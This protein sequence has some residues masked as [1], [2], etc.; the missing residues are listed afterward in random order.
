[1]LT[2]R[3]KADRAIM[4]ERLIALA[5]ECGAKAEIEDWYPRVHPRGV[6]VRIVGPRGLEV[7]ID[8]DG[9]SSQPDTICLPWCI[10]VD[11]NA[12]LANT[13]GDVNQFHH[14]KCT[15]FAE[16]F[17]DLLRQVR[18]GLELANNGAAFCP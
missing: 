9:E 5:V 18:R 7:G 1:M 8:F 3:K 6:L 4:A 12:R 17:D 11:S 14:R 13:F 2:E 10:S 15:A 16:G